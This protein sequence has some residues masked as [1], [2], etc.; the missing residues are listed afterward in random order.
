MAHAR[1]AGSGATRETGITRLV[2]AEREWKEALERADAEAARLVADA[3][4]ADAAADA[5][6][7]SEIERLLAARAIETQTV[8]RE[9]CAAL[10]RQAE[11]HAERYDAAGV[12]IETRLASEI[13]DRLWGV[14]AA[15]P[16][17]AEEGT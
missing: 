8:L 7:E 3:R 13:A 12:A 6:L 10:C 16:A 14:T 2:A 15:A 4:A 5:A 1:P 17:L 11:E 9:R